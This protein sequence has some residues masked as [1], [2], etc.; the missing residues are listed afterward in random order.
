MIICTPTKEIIMKRHFFATASGIGIFSI[1]AVI[2]AIHCSNNPMYPVAGGL[3]PAESFSLSK[4]A[5]S[6]AYTNADGSF[7]FS[8]SVP[9]SWIKTLHGKQ[10]IKGTTDWSDVVV[11]SPSEKY[12]PRFTIISFSHDPGY[13]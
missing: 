3:V 8:Y 5:V 9:G 7:Q 6:E 10:S 11:Y 12:V 13:P 4:E 1:L 2:I